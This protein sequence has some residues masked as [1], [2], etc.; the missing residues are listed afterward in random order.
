MRQWPFFCAGTYVLF[1][2]ELASPVPAPLL[3]FGGISLLF[4]HD[5]LLL[6]LPCDVILSILPH[7]YHEAHSF[8]ANIAPSLDDGHEPLQFVGKGFQV[9][10]A[11]DCKRNIVAKV[12][13]CRELVFGELEEPSLARLGVGDDVGRGIATATLTRVSA[14]LAGAFLAGKGGHCG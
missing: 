7:L 9:F 11:G 1:S 12:R 6:I 13:R 4:L 14:L 5:L 3:F 10:G 2:L 8:V